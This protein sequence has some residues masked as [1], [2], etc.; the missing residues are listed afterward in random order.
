MTVSTKLID[1]TM[2]IK[3]ENGKVNAF[4][5]EL[6]KD[7]NDALDYAEMSAR[8]VVITGSDSIFSA[9]FDLEVVKSGDAQ[10]INELVGAGMTLL[11]RIYG[12]P[13]PVVAAARG[14][15]MAMG[16]LILL[17]SDFRI[18]QSLHAKYGLNETAIGLALPQTAIHLAKASLNPA[19]LKECILFSQVY[20]GESAVSAGYL[21]ISENKETILDTAIETA[22]KL[23]RL[24]TKAYAQNK[25]L[26]RDET[27][28]RMACR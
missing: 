17:A 4:S 14:H 12:L 21:D 5:L 26:L 10:S 20:D 24:S 18:G 27:L 25:H 9:G 23:E 2:M 6:I 3:M 28:V 11:H 13:M 1:Q 19:K 7:M 16:A 22:K 8:S 15:A